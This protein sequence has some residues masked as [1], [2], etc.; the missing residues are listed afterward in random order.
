MLPEVAAVACYDTAFYAS[1]P[2][3]A[4]TYAVPREWQQRYGCA[5][6]ASTAIARLL[7]LYMEP[8]SDPPPDPFRIARC[9]LA[10]FACLPGSG[11]Q[12]QWRSR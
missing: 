2:A 7:G 4:A 8:E 10:L 1:L 12:R 5:G 11:G 6:T 9:A 3:E